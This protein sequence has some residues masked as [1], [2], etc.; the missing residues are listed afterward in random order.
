MRKEEIRELGLQLGIDLI[1]FTTAQRLDGKLPES[2]RPSQV[3][4]YLPSFWVLAKHIPVGIMG[5][6]E[7][8]AK[9]LACGLVHRV[10]EEAA[11]ELAYHLEQREYLAV[12]LP[13]LVMDF[14]NRTELSNTPA[15]QGSLFLRLAAVEAGLGTPGLNHMLLTPKFGPRVYLCGLM[16]NLEV[17]VDEPL[18]DELCPGLQECGRCAAVCPADAIPRSARQGS[19][20]AE[21]RHLDE[22]ACSRYCQP[23]GVNAFV[24]HLR[25]IFNEKDA[26]GTRARID[27]P[28]TSL[29]WHHMVVLRQGAFTGCTRCLQVC[30]V[31]EDYDRIR[32]SPH[33]QADLPDG[34]RAQ[35][36]GDLVSIGN[37]SHG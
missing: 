26:Q 19:P 14:K 33:R 6:D 28:E 3:S 29:L 35:V 15:G 11:A 22:K 36:S 17:E 2:C 30:P 23:Y 8:E 37:Y 10:L 25:K 20:L 1:G 16:T 18:T 4:E 32:N 7:S 5:A 13:P 12:V 9:P 34:V 21:Y 27:A 31:G 24:E